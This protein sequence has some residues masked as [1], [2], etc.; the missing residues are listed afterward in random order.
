MLNFEVALY[1]PDD[2]ALE[3]ARLAEELRNENWFIYTEPRLLGVS[4]SISIAGARSEVLI[5]RVRALA[6]KKNL[7][8]LQAL[9]AEAEIMLCLLS[10]LGK[11]GIDPAILEALP[12]TRRAYV[13]ATPPRVNPSAWEFMNRLSRALGQLLRGVLEDRQTGEWLR[14]DGRVTRFVTGRPLPEVP[15]PLKEFFDRAKRDGFPVLSRNGVS[16]I[17]VA[18]LEPSQIDRLLETAETCLDAQWFAVIGELI[19]EDYKNRKGR[20]FVREHDAWFD[21]LRRRFPS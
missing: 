3:L 2:Q 8:E 5:E 17:D 19:L 15:P 12:E 1:T 9:V 13:V 7:E 10:S 18:R 21:E 16:M 4:E 20:E 11:G 14:A 6:E